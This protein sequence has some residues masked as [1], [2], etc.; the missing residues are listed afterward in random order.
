M[1]DETLHSTCTS[2]VLSVST[3][4]STQEKEHEELKELR[5]HESGAATKR[6]EGQRVGM[7]LLL[8]R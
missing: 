2:W 6:G 8:K 4:N 7:C 1:R 5:E 3:S